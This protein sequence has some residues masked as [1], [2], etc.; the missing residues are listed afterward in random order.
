MPAMLAYVDAEQRYRYHNRAFRAI[1][2]VRSENTEGR[3]LREVLGATTYAEIE[4]SAKQALSG[5]TVRFERTQRPAGNT[6]FRLSTQ[7]LLHF[8]DGGGVRLLRSADRHYGVEGP[9]CH[10]SPSTRGEAEESHAQKAHV[11]AIAEELTDWDD[12]A[13]RIQAALDNDEFCLYCQS[14]VPTA[15]DSSELPF[16][17]VLIRLKEEEQ[18]LILRGSFLPFAEE[19]CMLPALDRWVVR[20]L[21]NWVSNTPN[22]QKTIYSINISGAT[23]SDPDFPEFVREQLRSHPLDGSH[24]CFELAEIDALARQAEVANLIR[25]LKPDGC[26]F[27]LGKL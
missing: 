23:I 11:D 25:Q 10:N 18:N 21:L 8:G 5:C 16:Y 22:R 4:D 3:H 7:F 9:P 24:I 17:E 2:R 27:A 13:G 19:H 14:I 15:S 6:V 12:P 20:H 26:L 1:L